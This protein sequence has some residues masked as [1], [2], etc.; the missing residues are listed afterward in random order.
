MS[1]ESANFNP[2]SEIDPVRRS[3]ALRLML[4]LDGLRALGVILLLASSTLA[5]DVRSASAA[6]EVEAAEQATASVEVSPDQ[7][8]AGEETAPATESLEPSIAPD[9]MVDQELEESEE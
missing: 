9:E 4:R 2:R 6:P 8:S 3:P 1:C 7:A 5:L